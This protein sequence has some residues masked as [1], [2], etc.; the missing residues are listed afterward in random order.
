MTKKLI[1]I[2]TLLLSPLFGE[3][4][5]LNEN[6]KTSI[7]LSLN[8]LIKEVL[9]RNGDAIK[10]QLQVS[11]SANQVEYEEGIYDPLFT[12]NFLRQSTNVPNSVENEL[13]R[14]QET[15]QDR[16]DFF[17]AGVSGLLPSGAKWSFLYSNNK[18]NSSLIEQNKDYDTEY[19]TT[20]K[21]ELEQPLLKNAGIEITEAKIALS[22][23]ENKVKENGYKQKLMELQGL[24]IQVYW[25]LYGAQKIYKSWDNSIALAKKSLKD[26][27]LRA[28]SGKIAQTEVLEAKS[29]LNIRMSE[30]ENAKNR[31]NEAQNQVL[32]LLNLPFNQNNNFVF[33]ISDSPISDIKQLLNSKEYIELALEKWPEYQNAKQNVKKEQLQTKY[34][35]NQTLPQ[36]NIVGSLERTSLENNRS[37]SYDN[38]IDPEFSSWTM[39]VKLSMPILNQQANTSLEISKIKLQQA[40]IELATLENNL[41]NSIMTKIDNVN[42]SIKQYSLYKEGLDYKKYLLEIENNK[43]LLG[44]A[45]ARELFEKE[46]DYMNYQR[47][48][49]SSIINWKTS[50]ALLEISTGNLLKK[51]NIKIENLAQTSRTKSKKISDIFGENK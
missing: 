27:E 15:Y 30:Y 7:S 10:E 49:L 26:L 1:L 48:F 45:N 37:D 29:A 51:H 5:S 31:F 38:S 17:D 36:L 23:F 46:E 4:K 3:S 12:T 16:V 32:T 8:S 18:K 35:Q 14:Y 39:G 28:K 9:I 21:L 20:F 44:K 11:I 41:I 34:S 22:K 19:D 25:R 2:S 13:V 43:L 24:T 42:S 47:K 33:E 6:D 50:E 40:K